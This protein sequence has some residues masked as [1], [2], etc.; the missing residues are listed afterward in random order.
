MSA[1]N[2]RELGDDAGPADQLGVLEVGV[3][4]PLEPGLAVDVALDQV[5]AVGVVDRESMSANAAVD[6]LRHH[7][8][9]ALRQLVARE[10]AR[11]AAALIRRSPCGAPSGRWSRPDRSP[12]RWRTLSPAPAC[13]SA[14]TARRSRMR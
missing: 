7:G 8:A 6:A 12:G 1:S 11:L 10:L 4:E 14:C 3:H 9:P 5:H 2:W 13:R